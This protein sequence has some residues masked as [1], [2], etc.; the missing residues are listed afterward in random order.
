MMLKLIW[1]ICLIIVLCIL[2]V[3][4]IAYLIL[5]FYP[6]IGRTPTRDMQKYYASKSKLYY[7]GKFHNKKQTN[8]NMSEYSDTNALDVTPKKDI[9]VLDIT[10]MEEPQKDKTTITWFGHS[11]LLIQMDGKNILTDPVLTE[12]A[13]PVN[14][15]GIKRFSKSPISIENMPEIDVL[16]ISHD[17]YDHLDYPTIRK[18]KQKVK[19]YIVPLGVE[20]YLKGW[21]IDDGKIISLNWWEDQKIGNISFTSIPAQHFSSRNPFKRD[22]TLWCGYLLKDN[23]N[24]IYFTGDT[25]YSDTFK[26]VY[27]RFGSVDVLMADTGQYNRAWAGIH[28]NPYDALGAAADVRAKHY[29]PIHWGTFVLSNHNWFEPADIT[30]KKQQEYGVSVVTPRIGETFDIN[31]I[32]DY[33]NRWWED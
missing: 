8:I 22:V 31:D 21:G 18:L 13:S 27:E 15:T 26:E 28:M 9:Q 17:H 24:S 16:L 1:K 5:R 7:D 4:L 14:F 2:T 23:K 19:R 11:C 32:G 33:T 3:L 20:S 29:M 12:Y 10:E 25:G 30:T 6:G